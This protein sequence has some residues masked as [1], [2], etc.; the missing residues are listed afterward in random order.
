MI[1]HDK[2]MTND[3]APMTNARTALREHSQPEMTRNFAFELAKWGPNAPYETLSRTQAESY[4]RQLAR[5]HYENFTVA[6]WLL[7]RPLRQHFYNIYSYC[8]W[9][10]DLADE[11]AGGQ[12]ALELLDWWERELDAMYAGETKHPVFVAL[13]HTVREFDI[14]RQPLANLLIAFRQDQT[15]TRYETFEELLEYC[16]HS[17]NPVGRLVLHLGRAFNEENAELSGMVC[18][19]LQLA[20][21]WQDVKRDWERGR[22]YLPQ[23]DLRHFGYTEDDPDWG[24][25][26]PPFKR[27]MCMEV[28]RAEARL[29]AGRPLMAR[30]PP[31]LRWEVDLF[32]RGGLA[33]LAAI[34]RQD[35]DVWSRRPV[36]GPLH[37]LSLLGQAWW[38]GVAL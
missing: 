37:K 3:Q 5:S 36:V 22:V 34:R 18:T 16:R 17:A 9:A 10:D 32:I 24:R 1:M 12:V 15:K 23:E 26:T 20:N 4:C 38:K 14:P 33:V 28:D 2:K 13:E 30:V 29:I 11:T 31:E 7:P 21:F 19:G 35:F 8:R 27:M 25:A 6:S